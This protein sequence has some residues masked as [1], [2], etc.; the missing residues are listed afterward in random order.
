MPQRPFK[1]SPPLLN[2]FGDTPLVRVVDFFLTFQEFDYSKSQ[3]ATEA[4]VSRITVD[5]I[6]PRL[7]KAGI[8]IRTRTVG[9][10][11]LY[12]LNASNPRV[13]ALIE[14]DL[15]LSGAAAR[16]QLVAAEA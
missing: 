13:Q 16:E 11:N 9:N 15:K 14:M 8:I 7:T 1:P 4:D 6:W 2:L 3:V 10:A 12:K 5:K